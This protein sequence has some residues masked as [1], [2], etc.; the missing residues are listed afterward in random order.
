MMTASR[1]QKTQGRPEIAVAA[2]QDREQSL[3]RMR[4]E[5]ALIP[6]EDICSITFQNHAPR[7]NLG[8]LSEEHGK[9]NKYHVYAASDAGA[10]KDICTK[11]LDHVLRYGQGGLKQFVLSRLDRLHLA[12]TLASSLLQ[13][14]ST[15]WLQG[16]WRS[17]DIL[18]LVNGNGVVRSQKV[19]YPYISQTD[20]TAGGI[21]GKAVNSIQ[22][23]AHLVRSEVLYALAQLLVELCFGMS[24]SKK[25]DPQDLD[26]EGRQE[27]TEMN[28]LRR[29]L[30]QC[31]IDNEIGKWYGDVVWTCLYCP[32]K[33]REIDFDDEET[34]SAVY[35]DIVMPLAKGLQIFQGGTNA[36]K[37]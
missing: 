23:R 26:P 1:L 22:L 15:P 12:V 34:V 13:L 3:Q 19:V 5:P 18:L 27:I 4:H 7:A 33:K 37:D 20:S 16:Q 35:E 10:H 14:D 9:G 21:K 29:L 17:S 8:S 24:L 28:I 30:D 36:F 6:I 2:S 32:F 25:F 11:R 31:D